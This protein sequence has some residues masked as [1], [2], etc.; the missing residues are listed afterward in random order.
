[1]II[2][3][4]EDNRGG[5]RRV[6]VH[7]LVGGRGLYV[8][9]FKSAG[10]SDLQ[11]W[12]WAEGARAKLVTA[13]VMKTAPTDSSGIDIASGFPPDKGIGMTCVANWSW[14]P[15]EGANDQLLF[16]RGA[17]IKE[18]KVFDNDRQDWLHGTYMGKRGIFP[19]PYV[20]IMDEGTIS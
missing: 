13:D 15:A 14:Y 3:G 11:L 12:S 16:P 1:M 5:Q 17:E 9:P 7:D 2:I 4:F 8:E 18:V 10:H 20:R 19:A 6:I